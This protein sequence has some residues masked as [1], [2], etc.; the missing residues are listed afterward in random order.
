MTTLRGGDVLCS[1]VSAARFV[2]IDAGQAGATP[3]IDGVP[4]VPGKPQPCGTARLG[5]ALPLRAGARYVDT[6]TGMIMLCVRSGDGS[7]ECE[8]RPMMDEGLA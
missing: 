5:Q 8:G 1:S 6:T 3:T 2:V 7:L 4:M